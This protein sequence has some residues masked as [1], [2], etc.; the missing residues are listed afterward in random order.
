MPDSKFH[1]MFNDLG[2][3]DQAYRRS[4]LGL[5]NLNEYAEGLA[6]IKQGKYGLIGMSLGG[7]FTALDLRLQKKIKAAVII[8][9]AGDN[10]T[11]LTESRNPAMTLLRQMRMNKFKR[12]RFL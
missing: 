2:V 9:G 12:K 8:A 10:P 5:E 3:H 11:I 6:F 4:V 7:I 1:L